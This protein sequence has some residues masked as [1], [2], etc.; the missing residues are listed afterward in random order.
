MSKLHELVKCRN[1]LLDKINDL[2]LSSDIE[3]KVNILKK[4]GRENPIYGARLD[5]LISNYEQV[6]LQN[7]RTL[8]NINIAI[9]QLNNDIDQLSMQLFDSEQYRREFSE[10]NI[11]QY[12][13]LTN[14][15]ESHIVSKI[16]A[17]SD[18]HYP[19]LQISPRF[20]KWVDEMVS[21]DPLYLTDSNINRLTEIISTYP[22]AYQRRLRLYE[23]ADRDF[24]ILPQN[25][26]GFVLSWDNFNYLSIE[27]IESYIKEVFNLLRPGGSFIFSYNN[28][29]LVGPA[30]RAEYHAGSYCNIRILT[31]LFDKF[32]YEIIEFKNIDTGDAFNTHISW[33]EVRKPGTLTTVKAHQA[34]AQIIEK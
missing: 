33:A 21:A 20:K 26:F 34:M 2:D 3:N 29:D 18:W 12:M 10:E 32:G 19:A 31:T 13:E 16:S 22:E 23:I 30:I 7:S 8:T 17:G 1:D 4:F 24:S 6:S 5:S 27:K 15:I 14:E 9:D 28:C 25:Q 11:T